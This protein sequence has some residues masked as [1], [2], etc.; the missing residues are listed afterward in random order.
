MKLITR[1]TDYAIRALCCMAAKGGEVISVKDM[2]SSL[3]I[4]RPFLRKILQKLHKEG[5]LTAMKGKG[6]GFK[7]SSSLPETTLF[8]V[9]MIF[10]GDFSLSDHTSGKIAC[11]GMNSCKLKIHIDGL[12]QTVAN[13]LKNIRIKELV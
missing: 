4:P 10:Q 2:A 13:R 1:D 3:S 11:P 5:I 9:V 8:N 12:E 7:G 6:G